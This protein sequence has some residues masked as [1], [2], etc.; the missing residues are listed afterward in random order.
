MA[1]LLRQFFSIVLANEGLFDAPEGGS[2]LPAISARCHAVAYGADG[3]PDSTTQPAAV[4]PCC[5]CKGC[6]A[7]GHLSAVGRVLAKQLLDGWVAPGPCSFVWHYL[8]SSHEDALQ[9]AEG[10]LSSLAELDPALARSW[11]SLLLQ[12]ADPNLDYPLC[13]ESFTHAVC[14]P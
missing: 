1:P 6:V 5:G 10:A 3:R 7:L 9:T 11:R 8:R 2:P 13:V 12:P 14:S 4:H